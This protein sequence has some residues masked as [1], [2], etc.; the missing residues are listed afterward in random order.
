MMMMMTMMMMIIIM[1]SRRKEVD[2]EV[3][4]D[5]NGRQSALGYR[6]PPTEKN[7]QPTE[8]K[9]RESKVTYQFSLRR[10]HGSKLRLSNRPTV[11]CI[12]FRHP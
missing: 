10:N 7:K 1:K 8:R 5:S 9:F 6:Q 2:E 11:P 12:Q 3:V 4:P